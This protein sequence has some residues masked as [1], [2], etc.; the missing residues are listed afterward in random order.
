M[1][2]VTA[3]GPRTAAGK[4]ISRRNALRHGLRAPEI[5][6]A[7]EKPRDLADLDQRL[8]EDLKPVGEL[9]DVL[10][11]QS[12]WNVLSIARLRC[13]SRSAPTTPNASGAPTLRARKT[14]RRGRDSNPNQWARLEAAKVT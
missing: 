10:S 13:S 7:T 4:R 9:E 2:Q 11:W 6:L 3:V 1:K 8:R 12:R 14:K 5:L